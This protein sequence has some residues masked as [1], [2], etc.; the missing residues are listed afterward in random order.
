M[1]PSMYPATTVDISLALANDYL[2]GPTTNWYVNCS[3]FYCD[4]RGDLMFWSC[5]VRTFPFQLNGGMHC[6][7]F[8]LFLSLQT[9]LA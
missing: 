1:Y 3:I 6:Y 7:I 4:C 5:E 8:V 9:V 2:F